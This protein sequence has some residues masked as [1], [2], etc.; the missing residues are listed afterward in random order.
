MSI[1]RMFRMIW[2]VNAVLILMVGVG[3]TGLLGFL[4]YE[5]FKDKF[6]I[7]Q[8]NETVNVS[9]DAG[10]SSE[11]TLG[12]FER[13]EGTDYLMAPAHSK[14]SYQVSYYD[15]DASAVRN[16]LF[17]N[18]V[19]KTT[20]WLVPGNGF[21][22]LSAER[23]L[24][25]ANERQDDRVHWMKYEVVKSDDNGDNRLTSEDTRAVAISSPTGEGY[26]EVIVSVERI[27]GTKM[28]D[29]NTLLVFHRSGGGDYVSEI[30]LPERRVN[31]TKELPKI[32]PN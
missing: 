27:L 10:T 20:R 3:L 1:A 8:V 24:M 29:E 5:I 23:L 30:N 25:P 6:R 2:R 21:L 14:Q 12:G 4:G 13:V 16:Y 15:K 32:R 28:R 22:F 31:V 18:A 19:D 26:A 11:W 17:I 7:R 9:P